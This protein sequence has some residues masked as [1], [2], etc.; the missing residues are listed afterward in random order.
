MGDSNHR[1]YGA[2]P[3]GP[4][5]Q[6]FGKPFGSWKPPSA[7]RVFERTR[8]HDGCPHCYLPCG[9]RRRGTR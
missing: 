4:E 3:P 5:H 8:R 9:C 7:R 6:T 2:A 1:T